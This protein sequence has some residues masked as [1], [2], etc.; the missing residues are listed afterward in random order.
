[1]MV[2]KINKDTGEMKGYNCWPANYTKNN[3]AFAG[4]VLDGQNLWLIPSGADRIIKISQPPT[5]VSAVT[6]KDGIVISL[7]FNKNISDPAGKEG[8][9]SLTVDGLPRS[10][11]S[12]GLEQNIKT[13]DLTLDTP[14]LHGQNV[15]ISYAA[16]DVKAEDG[17]FLESFSNQAVTNNVPASS[18]AYLSGLRLSNGE[19]NPAFKKNTTIYTADVGTNVSSLTITASAE[20]EHATIKVN[21]DHVD[22]GS[23][24]QPMRLNGGEN[25]ISIEVT[26]QDGVARQVYTINVN[27]TNV[28]TCDLVFQGPLELGSQTAYPGGKVKINCYITN[29]G[30]L[31][32]SPCYIKYYLLENQE[33]N[34]SPE[35]CR[36]QKRVSGLKPGSNKKSSIILP[37]PASI[38]SNVGY[39]TAVIDGDNV[40]PEMDK[41]NNTIGTSIDF[42]YPDLTFSGD[43]QLTPIGARPG[44]KVK[45]KDLVINQ[46]LAPSGKTSVKYYLWDGDNQATRILVGKRNISS[47]KPGK[48]S[49]GRIAFTIPTT[50]T[51]GVWCLQSVIDESDL[52]YEP[53]G[54]ENNSANHN[55]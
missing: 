42:T 55:L 34:I 5:V 20:E 39:I 19:L 51:S 16:G 2:I 8:Q 43:F 24:S 29:N 35:K 17:S 14:I 21:G 36:G 11:T 25:I 3:Y 49:K 41:W 52:V 50:P 6:S 26:A 48:T 12:V 4:G 54:E 18:N 15:L 31:K 27:R 45:V 38:T 28:A 33:D 30:F 9:F 53:D 37:I 1:N 40:N 23:T 13:I 46:G 7:E 47:L 32:S 22:S 44:T 10:V